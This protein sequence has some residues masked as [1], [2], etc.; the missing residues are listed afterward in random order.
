M[1]TLQSGYLLVWVIRIDTIVR[2]PEDNIVHV[3]ICLHNCIFCIFPLIN[4]WNPSFYMLYQQ[5]KFGSKPDFSIIWIMWF[6][7]SGLSSLYYVSCFTCHTSLVL[8]P[9]IS[10]NYPRISSSFLYG[11]SSISWSKKYSVS[12]LKFPMQHVENSVPPLL[13]TVE[14]LDIVLYTIINNSER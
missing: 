4:C 3:F 12:I 13:H 8:G 5:Y 14:S 1:Y 2:T 7:C 11:I 9:C 10:L 6:N